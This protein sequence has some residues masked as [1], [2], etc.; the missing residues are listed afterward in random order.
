MVHRDCILTLST[1]SKINLEQLVIK[2]FSCTVSVTYHSA[3]NTLP[4]CMNLL[5]RKKITINEADRTKWYAFVIHHSAP[6]NGREI[7]N[8]HLTFI[9]KS[10]PKVKYTMYQK[11]L[12]LQLLL[13]ISEVYLKRMRTNSQTQR[14]RTTCTRTYTSITSQVSNVSKQRITGMLPS[15]MVSEWTWDAVHLPPLGHSHF[16]SLSPFTR[17][18]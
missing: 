4:K 10:I 5:I 13:L 11:S 2:Y 15:I 16:L 12:Q 17:T 14:C 7:Y 18:E 1:L 3:I 9:T 6:V 8:K